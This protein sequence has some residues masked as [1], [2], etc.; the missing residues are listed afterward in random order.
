MK[1]LVRDKSPVE[2]EQI[3]RK[4]LTA[5]G[6]AEDIVER[7][8]KDQAYSP[9]DKT[10]I[11]GELDGLKG[12][13]NRGTFVAAAA[14]IDTPSKAVFMRYRAQ[15]IGAHQ[16]VAHTA[17]RFTVID[18]TVFLKTKKGEIVG[19]F[20]IDFVAKTDALS[21]KIESLDRAIEKQKGVSGKHLRIG[22]SLDVEARKLIERKGWQIHDNQFANLWL[23]MESR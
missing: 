22:G 20:P 1:A 23:A 10:I 5:M 16:G 15:M 6:I 13:K 3:N 4:K 12:V 17:D 14:D 21:A 8:L 18:Q 11:V 9:Q 7:F 19:Y 2:L